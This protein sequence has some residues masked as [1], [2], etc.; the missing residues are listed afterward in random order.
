MIVVGSGGHAHAVARMF[1]HSP[2]PWEVFRDSPTAR[3]WAVVGVGCSDFS[4]R[5]EIY[6]ALV[7]WGCLGGPLVHDKAVVPWYEQVAGGTVVF[8]GAVIGVNALIGRNVVVYSNAVVEHD[9]IVGDH[10]W[11]SP[12]VI[13]CGNVTVKPRVFLGAGA[14]VLPGVTLYEGCRIGAGA[15]VHEDVAAGETVYGPKDRATPRPR[16]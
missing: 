14:V 10:A 8:A 6:T 11:L 5:E 15:V 1:G 12:G 4:L 13:L 2:K 7:G 16:L 9:S 3:E